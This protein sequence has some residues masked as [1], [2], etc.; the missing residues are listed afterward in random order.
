VAGEYI[1]KFHK[2]LVQISGR[3]TDKINVMCRKH[4]Y[5]GSAVSHYQAMKPRQKNKKITKK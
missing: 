1:A 3:Q 5:T 2:I 4:K